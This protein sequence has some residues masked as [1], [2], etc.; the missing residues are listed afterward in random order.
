MNPRTYY[1]DHWLE[2]EPERFA[3][4]EEM[5]RWRP[6]LEPLLAPLAPAP[7]QT[8][9]DY[10]CGP[11]ELALELA[12][13]VGPDGHVHA[14]DI[15]ARFLARTRELAAEARGAAP[16]STHLLRDEHVPLPDACL[17][18]AICKNVLEYVADPERTLRELRRLMRPAGILL[19][20]DSDWEMLVVEGIADE[21]WAELFAAATIAYRTP[22]IGRKLYGLARRAGFREVSVAVIAVTDTEGQLL[23]ILV[24]LASYARVSGRLDPARIDEVLDAL[25]H[26]REAGTYLAVLPQFVVTATA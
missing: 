23:P 4:Y 1:R 26:A 16:V 2:I 18:R 9:L 20:T 21:R 11:G 5:F 25:A 24:N 15:N 13:R 3:A 8:V 17:D 14:A 19:A 6:E 10:G 22:R 7:G 12:R